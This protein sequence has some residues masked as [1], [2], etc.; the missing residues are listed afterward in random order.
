VLDAFS[1]RCVGW[2]LSRD[3][4]TRLTLAALERGLT[5]RR[6]PAGL[7]HHSD[8]GVQYASGNPFDN[9][10]AESFFKT[11]KTGEVYLKEYQDFAEAKDNLGPFIEAVYNHKRL[12]S[13]LG[14]LPPAEFESA[15]RENDDEP[16]GLA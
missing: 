4:D 9:A 11:L 14:Y 1:R 5:E 15:F 6:P 12:H 3:I 16:A 8:R 10:K 7:I 13:A 2:H